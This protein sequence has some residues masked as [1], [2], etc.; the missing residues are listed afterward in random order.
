MAVGRDLIWRDAGHRLGGSGQNAERQPCR[1]ARLDSTSTRFPFRSMARYTAPAPVH[2]RYV[3]STYELRSPGRAGA[4]AAPRRGRR[5]FGPRTRMP[6]GDTMPRTATSADRGGSS[7]PALEML[8]G[9]RVRADAGECTEDEPALDL[10]LQLLL[11]VSL[12]SAWVD[13]FDRNGRRVDRTHTV[14]SCK[15]KWFM[16]AGRSTNS[17]GTYKLWALAC[18]ACSHAKLNSPRGPSRP[19]LDA[20]CAGD[21]VAR[22]AS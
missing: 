6:H 7:V 5:E 4:A 8:F 19:R 2:F 15:A 11:T 3:S 17:P 20:R 9:R 18:S 10:P 13:V 14:A 1:G 12:S 16:L 22:S 21:L